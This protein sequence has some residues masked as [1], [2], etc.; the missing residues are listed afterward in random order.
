MKNVK[1]NKKQNTWTVTLPNG[2]TKTYKT[3]RGALN[4]AA[5]NAVQLDIP[6]IL[7][8][9]CYFWTPNGSASG[10]R[11]NENRREGEASIFV[12]ALAKLTGKKAPWNLHFSY[13]ET[14]KNVYKTVTYEIDGNTTNITGFIVGMARRGITLIK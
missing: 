8:A 7:T 1:Q 6:A 13:E 14:C 3:E 9:N 2:N 5:K 4:C 10:R 12:K 11:S